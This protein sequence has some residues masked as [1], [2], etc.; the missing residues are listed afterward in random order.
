MSHGNKRLEKNPDIEPGLVIY[1]GWYMDIFIS[2][3]YQGK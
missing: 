3:K 2:I 1:L